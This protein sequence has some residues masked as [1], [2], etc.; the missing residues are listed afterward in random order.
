MELVGFM[1]QDG[2]LRSLQMEYYDRF[3]G[4]R[5]APTWHLRV[6]HQLSEVFLAGGFLNPCK[7]AKTIQ[8]I[9]YPKIV[10]EISLYFEITV[11]WKRPFIR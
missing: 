1:V 8:N 3:R 11:F 2:P 5:W 9:V 10:D 4:T 7:S 6:I